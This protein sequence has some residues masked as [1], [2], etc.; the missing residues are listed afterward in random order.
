MVPVVPFLSAT[1]NY[2]NLVFPLAAISMLLTTVIAK[3]R[4]IKLSHVLLLVL[5][6]SAGLMVKFSF[7]PIIAATFLFL[8]AHPI[9]GR[10]KISNDLNKSWRSL[11]LIAVT[12]LVFLTAFMSVGMNIIQYRTLTNP[13]CEVM[14]EKERCARNRVN[15]NRYRF[16]KAASRRT[17]PDAIAFVGMYTKG[18]GET[19]TLLL[20]R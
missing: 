18:M 6:L 19:F 20:T 17:R 9:L 16:E 13:N 12:S 8:L 10:K 15:A 11:V 3:S 5:T 7:I 4:S 14:M 2:D 1:V